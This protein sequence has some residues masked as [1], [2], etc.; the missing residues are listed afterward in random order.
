MKIVFPISRD[1][2][3]PA[4]YAFTLLEVMIAIGIFFMVAFTVLALVSQCLGQARALQTARSPVGS[5]AAQTVLTNQLEEGVESGDFGDIFPDHRWERDVYEAG[6]N[7]LYEVTLTTTRSGQSKPD[8]ELILYLFRPATS[9]A[10]RPG[11]LR[12]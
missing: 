2:Y 9:G 12:R 1:R 8:G 5:L 7:G 4:R 10:R 3:T 6:T 11:G